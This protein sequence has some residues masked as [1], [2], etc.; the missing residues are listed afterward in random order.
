MDRVKFL[1]FFSK[2]LLTAFVSCVFFLFSSL[3]GSHY[4]DSNGPHRLAIS[5]EVYYSH[6][7][8][9]GGTH[10]DGVLVGGRINYERIKRCGYYWAM[11]GMYACGRMEGE[12]RDGIKL[13]SWL[14]EM[15][16]EGRFGYTF[17][18]KYSPQFAFTPFFGLG[19]Y[20]LENEFEAPSPSIVTFEDSFTFALWG[21]TTSLKIGDC[22]RLGVIFK[23]KMMVEGDE[24]IHNHDEG[25]DYEGKID[26]RMQYEF[27]LPATTRFEYYSRLWELSI[28]PFY[29]LRHLGGRENYPYDFFETKYHQ[30]GIRVDFA[31]RF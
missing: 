14:T 20:R 26:E 27:Y 22:W 23:G 18:F 24:E 1:S 16:I 4:V 30:Y 19:G 12:N 11:E 7:L 2:G 29:R 13:K 21:F 6:R 8:R 5:P 3:E 9:E 25:K 28:V 15:E 17:Q 10:Q 31:A